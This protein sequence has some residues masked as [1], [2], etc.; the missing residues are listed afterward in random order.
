MDLKTRR[1]SFDLAVAL[2]WALCIFQHMTLVSVA[3]LLVT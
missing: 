2:H 3:T 1:Y